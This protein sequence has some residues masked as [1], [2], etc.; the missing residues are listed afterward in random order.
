MTVWEEGYSYELSGDTAINIASLDG[1]YASIRYVGI[2]HPWHT[3]EN[4]RGR[5]S[6]DTEYALA[7]ALIA[8]NEQRR[9]LRRTAV[10]IDAVIGEHVICTPSGVD[11]PALGAHVWR[12]DFPE[13]I[14][15]T[16]TAGK[17]FFAW[18]N[19]NAERGADLD[20]ES[21][22]DEWCKTDTFVNCGSMTVTA[23]RRKRPSS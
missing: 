21:I 15:P 20:V 16:I 9:K 6:T 19:L 7:Q 13:A 22:E 3:I 14:R 8:A 10:Y 17:V 23:L 18:V 12:E 5:C 4:G 11:L 1:G 2:G